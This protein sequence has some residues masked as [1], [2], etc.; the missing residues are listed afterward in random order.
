MTA[1]TVRVPAKINLQLAVGALRADGYHELVSVFMSVGLFDELTAELADSPAVTVE[2]AESAGVPP[3]RSN[4]AM[5]AADRLAAHTGRAPG[6][7]LRIR[8]NIPAAAGL[9]GGSADA[10]AALLA[11]DRLWDTRLPPDELGAI[12]AQLGSD[13]PFTLI[14]GVAVGEGRGEKLTPLTVEDS[15]HW[16]L[17]FGTGGLS[18]PAVYRQCDRLRAARAPGQPPDS[19][20]RTCVDPAIL[21]ALRSGDVQALATSLGE[22]GSRNDLSAAALSLRP[23]LRRTLAAGIEAGGL[24]A[25]VSGSG[26]TCVF[27]AEDAER[28]EQIVNGLRVSETCRAARAVVGPVTGATVA[29]AE[30]GGGN[31]R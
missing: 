29:A 4:L 1:V 10:A 21:R 23:E 15:F 8:K 5:L 14:G 27:L 24:A 28:A 22:P 25:F 26:P 3:D 31:G 16:V 19:G 18:T 11:C 17:A 7:H 9:A 2:G 20:Q 12:G 30:E 13:V 6:V